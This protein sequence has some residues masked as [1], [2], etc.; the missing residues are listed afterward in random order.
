LISWIGSGGSGRERF[1]NGE[2]KSRDWNLKLIVEGESVICE[3][4]R[5]RSALGRFALV[6][7]GERDRTGDH[8]RECRFVALEEME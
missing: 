7:V 1:G 6:E 2:T 4:I 3:K 5:R 8:R